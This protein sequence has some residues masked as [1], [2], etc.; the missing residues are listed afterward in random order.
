[1]VYGLLVCF[2][3]STHAGMFS[4]QL[5][6]SALRPRSRNRKRRIEKDGMLSTHSEI[7]RQIIRVLSK[8]NVAAITEITY[9]LNIHSHTSPIQFLTL[10]SF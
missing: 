3:N 1:M 10:N 8:I 5:R 9:T 2:D 4:V 7:I 6:L